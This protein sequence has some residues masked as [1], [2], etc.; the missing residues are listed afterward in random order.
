MFDFERG[1]AAAGGVYR[2]DSA[3]DPQHS[4][5]RANHLSREQRHIA[6]AAADIEDPHAGGK[7]DR[8]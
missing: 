5:G 4:A 7:P 6:G 8:S 2:G 3:V 1:H